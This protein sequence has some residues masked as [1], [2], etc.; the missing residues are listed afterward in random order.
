V[1]CDSW[2]IASRHIFPFKG[3]CFRPNNG[4]TGQNVTELGIELGKQ[5]V[6]DRITQPQDEQIADVPQAVI[7]S[8]KLLN[9]I[10]GGIDAIRDSDK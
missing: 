8:V 2:Q 10:D 6:A 4:P 9:L 7:V 5:I 1:E 3:V